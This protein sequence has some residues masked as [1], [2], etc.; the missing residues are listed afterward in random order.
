MKSAVLIDTSAWIEFLRARQAPVADLVEQF[1]TMGTA[2]LCEPVKAELL[3]G[4]KGSKERQQLQTIFSVVENIDMQE[5]D[6]LLAGTRLQALREK[7][8]TLA[9]TD[10]LIATLAQRADAAILTLD[11]H[12]Q[13][14]SVKLIAV[15]A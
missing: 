3:Q 9:L 4:A 2:R 5:S 13:H 11:A 10:A 12:F 14:L 6:W 1:L 8:I 15:P 7:G